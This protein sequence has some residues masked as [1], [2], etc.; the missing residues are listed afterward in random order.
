ME[1]FLYLSFF[2]IFVWFV[3][4]YVFEIHSFEQMLLLGELFRTQQQNKAH[5]FKDNPFVTFSVLD[6][7]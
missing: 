2:I 1:Y 5:R 3:G 6:T 4:V 7:G